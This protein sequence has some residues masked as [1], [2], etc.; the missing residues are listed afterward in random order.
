MDDAQRGDGGRALSLAPLTVLELGPDELVDVAAAA[1]FDAVGLRLI[2]AT[3]EEPLRPAVGRTPLVRDIKRRLDDT[4]LRLVDIEVLRLRPDTHVR[5]DYGV[6]L[7]TGAFLGAEQVLVT[8]NDPDH[9]RTAD[10]FAELA[11]LCAEHGLTPNLEPMPWTEVADLQ[12]AV[13]ILARAGHDNAGL[14]VDAIHWDRARNTPAQLAALPRNWIR[15]AQICDAV[16]PRPT[17]VDEMMYQGRS[18]RLF[19]GQGSIDLVAMLYALPAGIPISVE[20]PVRWDAPAQVRARAA[21]RA[22]RAVLDLVDR[23]EGRQTARY[24]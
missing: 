2:R 10:R 21:Q 9:H 17:T 15:Y 4:G 22:A 12:Q 18:A 13:S 3:P 7:E 19:P 8:G 6:F 23:D 5:D 11:Q 16:A 14:L 24:A 20:A 1:G